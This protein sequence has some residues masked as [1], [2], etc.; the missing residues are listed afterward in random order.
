MANALCDETLFPKGRRNPQW[1]YF[2]DPAGLVTIDDTCAFYE[3]SAETP[4]DCMNACAYRAPN[5]TGFNWEVGPDA[6]GRCRLTGPTPVRNLRPTTSQP[7]P[8]NQGKYQWNQLTTTGG[9]PVYLPVQ[10]VPLNINAPVTC[11]APL[12]TACTLP[13]QTGGKSGFDETYSANVKAQVACD[14][15]AS[16]AGYVVDFTN[17]WW[18][19]FTLDQVGGSATVDT[20]T[21]TDMPAPGFTTPTRDAVRQGADAHNGVR[22]YMTYVKA[23]KVYGGYAATM[24]GRRVTVPFNHKKRIISVLEIVLPIVGALGVVAITVAIARAMYKRSLSGR[25]A[26]SSRRQEKMSAQLRKSD[27]ASDLF[28]KGHIA[29]AFRES[30]IPLPQTNV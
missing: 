15:D 24:N 19:T 11:K 25:I 21:A 3:E 16:C 7:N 2:V 4:V 12:Y 1:P 5:C 18:S 29:D 22:N 8:P 10:G 9:G 26:A 17:V 30:S 23:K 27:P 13:S 20:V 28:G 14:A 6:V